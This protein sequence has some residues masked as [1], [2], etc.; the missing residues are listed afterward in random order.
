M[1]NEG[2]IQ[3]QLDF[4]YK[5][6]AY[7]SH[8]AEEAIKRQDFNSMAA[9]NAGQIRRMCTTLEWVLTGKTLPPV[10]RDD[11]TPYWLNV[12]SLPNADT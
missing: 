8:E 9:T 7:W 11:G 6:L 3:K 12:I 10:F 1:K 5:A 2:E 4:L